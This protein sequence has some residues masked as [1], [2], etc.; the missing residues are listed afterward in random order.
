MRVTLYIL[1]CNYE[2]YLSEAIESALAQDY[3]DIELVIID[4]GSKDNS[5][6][7]INH[8]VQQY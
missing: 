2:Q 3:Q 8:Y 7:V 4:D 1:N 5:Q 6:N